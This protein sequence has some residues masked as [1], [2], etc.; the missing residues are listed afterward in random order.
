MFRGSWFVVEEPAFLR[1][2]R[3]DCGVAICK[4]LRALVLVRVGLFPPDRDIQKLVV[5]GRPRDG[6]LS[7]DRSTGRNSSLQITKI[8]L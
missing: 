6:A 8:W 5:L 2:P 3:F 4:G 7:G 1:Q